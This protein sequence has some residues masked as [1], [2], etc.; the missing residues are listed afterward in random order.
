[1]RERAASSP[2]IRARMSESPWCPRTR[3][4]SAGFS[5]PVTTASAEAQTWFDRG[6]AWWLRL[7]PRRGGALLPASRRGRPGLRDGALGIAYAIGPN[8]NKDWVAFEPAELSSDGRRVHTPPSSER[9]GAARQRDAGRAGADRGA[10]DPL[11]GRRRRPRTAR[12]GTMPTPRRCAAVYGR[13][14]RRSRRGHAVRRGD[15]EAHA[16]AAVGPRRPASRPRAPTPLE[17]I[18][19]LERAHGASR[20]RRTR[21]CCTCTSTRWRCRRIP[22]RALPA[23]D[24]LRGLVPDAGHLQHMPTHIDVLCGHYATW[25]PGTSAAI[26]A[27]RKYLEREGRSTSTRSIAATISISRSTARCSSGQSR[28]RWRRPASCRTLA[29]ELLR[30]EVPPMADSAGGLRADAAA[31]AGALRQVA[32]DH[33][34]AAARRPGHCTA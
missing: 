3:T 5:H 6:L 10:G 4:I 17:A 30:I 1:M 9:A 23:A 7:Q 32:G 22:E 28:R 26:A 31:R 34:R 29:E 11:P 16:V 20:R 14:R 21:G 8:Y 15:D 19:V 13:V 18:A 12:P 2:P 33:R 27:D 24:R 25:W